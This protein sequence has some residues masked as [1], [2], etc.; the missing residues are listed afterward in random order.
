MAIKSLRFCLLKMS[1]FHLHIWS[2]VYPVVEQLVRPFFLQKLNILFQYLL[3]FIV[4]GEK[5]AI[6]LLLFFTHKMAF[7]SEC[8][9]VFL[10]SFFLQFNYDF[11]RSDFIFI[12]FWGF[13]ELSESSFLPNLGRFW[14]LVLQIFMLFSLSGIPVIC[15]LGCFI[16]SCSLGDLVYFYS[17]ISHFFGW[18]ISVDLYS[19]LSAISK[20]SLSLF[21]DFSYCR[22]DLYNFYY[23]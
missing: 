23:V 5:S 15:M 2:V 19:G 10:F 4:F 22:F 17:N 14:W 11:S 13:V 7:F 12:S 21:K 6:N 9:Q 18:I 16:L 3:A 8:F 20:L 1:L